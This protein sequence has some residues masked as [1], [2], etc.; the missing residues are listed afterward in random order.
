M[1]TGIS[2]VALRF[3]SIPMALITNIPFIQSLTITCKLLDDN[4]ARAHRIE[5]V[6]A[7]QV[8]CMCITIV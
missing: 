4:H 8:P 6:T 7:S 5:N 2:Q 3:L 1:A